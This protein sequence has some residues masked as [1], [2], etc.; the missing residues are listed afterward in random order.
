MP[1][2]P[3][4]APPRHF[5]FSLRSLFIATAALAI[6]AAQWPFYVP[7]GDFYRPRGQRHYEP[8]YEVKPGIIVVMGVGLL[9]GFCWLVGRWSRPAAH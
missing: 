4:E 7:T 2:D 8:V 6:L 1:Q 3:Y 5:R 9:I